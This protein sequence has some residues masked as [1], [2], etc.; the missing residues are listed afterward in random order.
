MHM[1]KMLRTASC[2]CALLFVTSSLTAQVVTGPYDYGTFDNQGFDT[3][4]VANLNVHFTVPIMNKTGRGARFSYNLAFD[5]SVWTPVSVNGV[6]QWQPSSTWGWTGLNPAGSVYVGYSMT[7]SS[8]TCGQYGQ[9]SYQIWSYSNVF[10][11]DEIGVLHRFNAG[12]SY[13]NS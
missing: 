7:T 6:M 2:V 1:F 4:N 8:G 13:I 10:Y 11:S 12:G 9:G 3:I 5:S